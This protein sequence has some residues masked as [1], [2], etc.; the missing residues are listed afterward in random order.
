MALPKILIH[1]HVTGGG[2][3]AGLPPTPLLGEARRMRDALV[4]DLIDT[5]RVRVSLL[6]DARVPA[7]PGVDAIC[8]ARDD[9]WDAL[10]DTAVTEADAVW[11]IAPETDGV[12]ERLAHRV[13]ALNRPLLSSEPEAIAIATSKWRTFQTLD[14]VGVPTVPTF[15]TADTPRPSSGEWIAKPDDGCGCEGVMRFDTRDAAFAWARG[16]HDSRPI[17][18][19]PRAAGEPMSFSAFAWNRRGWLLTANRQRITVRDDRFQLDGVD[20]NAMAP[21]D[22]ACSIV[23]RIAGALPGLKGHF[24][25]DVMRSPD[26]WTVIE[27]N[28]RLTTSYAGLRSTLT[29][30]PA[31]PVL[32]LWRDGGIDAMPANTGSTVTIQCGP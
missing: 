30:N 14:A 13:R 26:G 5:A 1:E 3:Q 25:V 24:G 21:G 6:H 32:N 19:Q 28:P 17:V 15:R 4:R 12:L 7:P 29:G 9:A 16:R 23:H 2:M 10:F 11:L 20:V 27:V 31:E 8:V 22:A 18:L